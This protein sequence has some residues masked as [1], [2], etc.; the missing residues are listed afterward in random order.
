MNEERC[1]VFQRK[2][3]ALRTEIC[4]LILW[5]VSAL[6][7]NDPL[8]LLNLL[9]WDVPVT[10]QTMTCWIEQQGAPELTSDEKMALA[11]PYFP[12]LVPRKH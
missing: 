7:H 8:V 9:V 11:R 5:V 10:V 3:S 1:E 12:Y 2:E 4:P 6:L